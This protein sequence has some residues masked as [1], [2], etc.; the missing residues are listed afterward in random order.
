MTSKR[1]WGMP[2]SSMS[3]WAMANPK[4]AWDMDGFA[5]GDVGEVEDPL[6]LLVEGGALVRGEHPGDEGLGKVG[7]L[8]LSPLG[9]VLDREALG[10]GPSL[11]LERVVQGDDGRPA[12]R[13]L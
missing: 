1:T 4:F 13:E 9:L 11:P 8:G 12:G 7:V 2:L 3:L 5:V 10:V 6:G